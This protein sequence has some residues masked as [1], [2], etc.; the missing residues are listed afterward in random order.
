[1]RLLIIYILIFSFSIGKLWG[2]TIEETSNFSDELFGLGSYD[3]ALSGYKRV[4]F[5]DSSNLWM[6]Y[7]KIG[8]CEWNL[9]QKTEAL[10]SFNRAA[11]LCEDEEGLVLIYFK[12]IGI[13]IQMQRYD[14]VLDE[15]NNS[16]LKLNLESQK[17]ELFF[18]GISNFALENYKQSRISFS[19][20]LAAPDLKSQHI[21]DS[22]FADTLGFNSPKPN[23]A[24]NLSYIIPGLGQMYAGDTKDGINSLIVNALFIGLFVNSAY[25]YTVLDA[26]LFVFPWLRRYYRGGANIAEETAIEKQNQKK[27]ICYLQIIRLIENQR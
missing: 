1:M 15:I 12:K 8:C 3:M 25:V 7:Y 22:L 18:N 23:M 24:K 11:F 21:L 26:S 2:Q 19:K 13:L 9:G 27:E 17:R 20:C 4:A 16:D 6:N 14:D 5:F 10:N